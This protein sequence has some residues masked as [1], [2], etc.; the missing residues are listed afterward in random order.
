MNDIQ[1]C[2][3]R[4]QRTITHFGIIQ[5]D[6]GKNVRLKSVAIWLMILFWRQVNFLPN[7]EGC[8][9]YCKS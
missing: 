1:V 8:P 3:Q 9:F 7:L 6:I 4:K 2:I 5:M